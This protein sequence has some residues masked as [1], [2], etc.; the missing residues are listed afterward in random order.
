[1]ADIFKPLEWVL[2]SQWSALCSDFK[3]SAIV[4]VFMKY[5]LSFNK[6]SD[7]G[8]FLSFPTV[9]SINIKIVSSSS[10]ALDKNDRSTERNGYW[11]DL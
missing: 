5:K 10:V 7:C 11:I 4:L 3:S 9:Q 1:M 8:V 6:D 2:K